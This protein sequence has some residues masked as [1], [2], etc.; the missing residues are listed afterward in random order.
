MGWQKIERHDKGYWERECRDGYETCCSEGLYSPKNQ[1]VQE[2]SE[3][4]SIVT[5]A[6]LQNVANHANQVCVKFLEPG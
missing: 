2:P 4:C 1:N 5:A 3:D 6:E